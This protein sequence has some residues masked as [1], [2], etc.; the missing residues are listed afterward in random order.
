MGKSLRRHTG[1]GIVLS[2]IA[3][4]GTW[5]SVQ[6]I[7]LWVD[8]LTGGTVPGAKANAHIISSLG[9][10]MGSL[11]APMVL[12]RLNRRT[13][14]TILCVLSL[15]VCGLLF[16]TQT[17]YTM[18]FLVMV[19]ATGACTAAFYGWF[20]L[21]LPELFPTRVRATGQGLCFNSGRIIAAAGA[22]ASGAL[23]HVLPDWINGRLT[24]YAAVPS[25]KLIPARTRAFLT[26]ISE[27]LP[28]KAQSA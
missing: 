6:W 7:P 9:A 27:W 18:P 21:Y 16:R 5:G 15:L 11:L 19:F 12:G 4:I 22:L 2:S 20:P 13:S 26:F 24:I 14:Y 23:V 28:G 10:T 3:L 25:R 17:G 1:I 8:Q